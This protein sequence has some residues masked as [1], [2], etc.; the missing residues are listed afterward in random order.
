MFGR[1]ARTRLY[2]IKELEEHISGDIEDNLEQQKKKQQRQ[3]KYYGG[4]RRDFIGGESILVTDYRGGSRKTWI[5]AVIKRRVG[6]TT[7]ICKLDTGG[8]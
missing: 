8:E 7:Y 2:Q 4:R 6:R 1:E 3:I 5:K